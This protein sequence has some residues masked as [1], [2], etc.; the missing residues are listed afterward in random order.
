MI[1]MKEGYRPADAEE[2][3]ERQEK[4]RESQETHGQ[5][6][7]HGL[8][9][10]P[11]TLCLPRPVLGGRSRQGQVQG[12]GGGDGVRGGEVWCIRWRIVEGVEGM[13]MSRVS[14][15]DYGGHP[16]GCFFSTSDRGLGGHGSEAWC[17]SHGG[18]TGDQTEW[19]FTQGGGLKQKGAFGFVCNVGME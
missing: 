9:L 2:R 11:A 16:S 7:S 19:K 15:S 1:D 5:R 4:A 8:I 12:D 3:R 6:G 13:G 17:S 14:N 10:G 18:R